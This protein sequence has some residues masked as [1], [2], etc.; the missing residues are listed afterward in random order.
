MPVQWMS[1]CGL[2]MWYAIKLYSS[3]LKSIF[4][5]WIGGSAAGPWWLAAHLSRQTLLVIRVMDIRFYISLLGQSL[6]QTFVEGHCPLVFWVE[7]QWLLNWR[8]LDS[9]FA[10]ESVSI[11][12]IRPSGHSRGSPCF[13]ILNSFEAMQGTEES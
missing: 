11:A 1:W 7:R 12:C 3:W 6:D 13:D 10:S 4:W 8:L 5:Y 2:E 9:K